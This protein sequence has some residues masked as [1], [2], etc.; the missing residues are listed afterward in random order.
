VAG[1]VVW[2]DAD[3]ITGL[4]D[5]DTVTT[6]ENLAETETYTS[7]GT[8]TYHTNVQNGLPVVRFG[9]SSHL[10][11]TVSRTLKP[12]TIFVAMK[13]GAVGGTRV[14]IGN[15]AGNGA[16]NYRQSSSKQNMLSEA[17]VNIASSTS[18]VVTTPA[19]YD[20]SYGS[21]GAWL[22]GL[23]GTDDG[24]GT[25]DQTISAAV[26]CI[27]ARD[28]GNEI[29]GS[30]DVYEILIYDNLVSSGDRTAIRDYLTAKW[31]I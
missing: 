29:L 16:M 8:P 18:N 17:L 4:S 30:G 5:T 15:V 27:G 20:A 23:N 3:A 2:L 10:D 9:A 11:G 19:V 13:W 12:C 7:T 25:N 1:L 22:F 26:V 28:S 24:S 14:V 31:G 6:W 21:A